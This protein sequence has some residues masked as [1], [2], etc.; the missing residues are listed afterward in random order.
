MGWNMQIRWRLLQVT[1]AIRP[2]LSGPVS[3]RMWYPKNFSSLVYGRTLL[4]Y[5]SPLPKRGWL[6]S[7]LR[8]QF[9]PYL[10]WEAF[11]D[12]RLGSGPLL[13]SHSP[14]TGI[15]WFP[16]ISPHHKMVSSVRS[17]WAS[18]WSPAVHLGPCTYQVLTKAE[19]V[20]SLPWIC[21][22]LPGTCYTLLSTCYSWA[23]G[24]STFQRSL[25]TFTGNLPTNMATQL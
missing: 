25:C 18:G 14:I 1:A 11:P 13:N 19:G 17:G 22:H 21:H 4:G 16:A 8:S 23:S 5:S 15:S 3:T 24:Y 2:S 12:P 6:V 10:L 20:K 7:S 9:S